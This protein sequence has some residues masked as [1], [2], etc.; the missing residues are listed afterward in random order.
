MSPKPFNLK[1][2]LSLVCVAFGPTLIPVQSSAQTTINVPGNQAT[3][4]AG[5]DAANPGDTV[6]VAP[7]TYAENINFHGKAVNLTSSAGASATIIDGGAKGPVVTFNTGETASSQLNGF[8]I[9]NGYQNGLSG[10][11]ILIANA[12]PTITGNVISGNRA[13]QGIGIYVNGGAPLIQ[14]NT[15]TG[16]NQANAGDGGGGGGGILVAGSSSTPANPQILGNTITNNSVSSGGPGGGISVTYF[17]SPLIQGNV[18]QGN[19]A[20]NGGGGINVQS[21]NSPVV[22]QNV[23]ANNSSLGGGSG[24]GLWVSP[25]S[26]QTTFLNNTIAG[27]TA[28]DNTSGI[29]VTGFG[30]YATFTNNIVVA[31]NGQNAV[32][33]NATYSAT[34]PFFSYNDA[35]S[36]SGS[37]WTG[38]CDSASHP[39]NISAD[40]QFVNA[41]TDFHLKPGSPAVDAGDNTPAN[42]PTFDLDGNVRIFDGNNDCVNAVDLGVF[43][44]HPAMAGAFSLTSLSFGSQTVGTTSS[45]QSTTFTSSGATC[46]QFAT[47]QITS[48]FTQSTTCPSNGVSGGSSC[49]FNVSFAPSSS[50]TKSGNLTVTSTAGDSLAVALTGTGNVP[51]PVASF[52][53]T[54]LVFSPQVLGTSSAPQSIALSN[55]GTAPLGIN[56]IS[57]TGDFGVSSGCGSSLNAGASCSLSVI[58]TPSTFGT[59]SGTLTVSENADSSPVNLGLSGTGVDFALSSSS[60]GVTLVRG[61]SFMFTVSA[62]PRGGTFGNTVSLTC[63]GMPAQSSCNLSPAQVIP[64]NTGASS[65]V[66]LTTD[67]AKTPIGTYTIT[68]TGVSVGLVRSVTFQLVVGKH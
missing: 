26:A 61:N 55:T 47:V 49:Q 25:S 15:I 16:N 24:G 60:S 12:S 37:A 51:A 3:I 45:P 59:E 20:Y 50:G 6:L 28:V 38:I 52:S 56:S 21:Y 48:D 7:G 66:T 63:S 8:T 58:F 30:Q 10:G 23:I 42:L 1:K 9:R 17:S 4:Q 54:S 31:A 19:V 32:T 36:N 57:A 44:L 40:P 64:G 53:P 5:I 27:N 43:E 34:S 68:I 46:F 62:A 35:F 65:T 33:C 2:L 14:N 41:G 11:G 29:Y 13:A 67:R 22:S 18:I 39:G